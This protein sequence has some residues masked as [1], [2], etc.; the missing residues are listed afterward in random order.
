MIEVK[1]LLF[2]PLTLHTR[3]GRGLHLGPRERLRLPDDE[4][5]PETDVARHNRTSSI[6]ISY[7][8]SSS[9]VSGQ[10]SSLDRYHCR[11]T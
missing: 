10:V 8:E 9:A 4:V 11:R 1:N 5:S 7:H 6:I 3:S 2:Q